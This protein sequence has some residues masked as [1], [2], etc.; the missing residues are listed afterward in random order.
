MP[1]YLGIP[2]W[3]DYSRLREFCKKDSSLAVHHPAFR[4]GYKKYWN[5]CRD[6]FDEWAFAQTL[7]EATAKKLRDRYKSGDELPRFIKYR[8]NTLQGLTA[9]PYCGLQK[10]I[11]TDHYL[12]KQHF[13]QYAVFSL[14]LV[15]ACTDC[16]MNG[17]KGEW[18]PGASKKKG[19]RP[20]RRP[21]RG[22]LE[23]L[24]HPYFDSFL[25][26][27]VLQIEFFPAEMLLE[28]EIFPIVRDKQ[29]RR[30]VSFHINQMNVQNAAAA[31]VRAYWSSLISRIQEKSELRDDREAI[32][33]FLKDELR[34][35]YMECKSANS[36]E[37]IFYSSVINSAAKLDFLIEMSRCPQKKPVNRKMPKGRLIR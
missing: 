5:A 15:P 13:P 24:L 19:E 9:C 27:Q 26:E 33:R 34:R 37:Y 7:G 14:N 12:P 30:L 18:F 1:N 6:P 36:I 20:K 16:Q 8:L 32:E 35:V 17:A 23:R 10:N 31:T 28:I 4:L 21:K 29:V 3:G 22:S 11:T 25:S 2:R